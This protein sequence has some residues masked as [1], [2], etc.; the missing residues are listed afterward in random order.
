MKKSR[1]KE[2]KRVAKLPQLVTDRVKIQ[3]SSNV[4]C[5]NLRLFPHTSPHNYSGLV[6]QALSSHSVNKNGGSKESPVRELAQKTPSKTF[7]LTARGGVAP[8]SECQL[9]MGAMLTKFLP[10]GNL[11]N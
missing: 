8:D 11:V 9:Q 10:G 4:T 1:P 5:T 6:P 7:V 2:V 3:L